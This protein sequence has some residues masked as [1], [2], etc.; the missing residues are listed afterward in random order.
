MNSKEIAPNILRWMSEAE[1]ARY[2]PRVTTGTSEPSLEPRKDSGEPEKLE[3]GKFA[4]WLKEQ[5]QAGRLEYFWQRTDKRATGKA[6]TPDFIVALPCG[7]T[8]WIE[9]KAPGG[10]LSPV[11][12]ATLKNLAILDH[13]TALCHSSAEAIALVARMLDIV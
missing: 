1:R 7:K 6:G 9:F 3:Q 8:Y 13:R 10:T 4:K 2:A 5:W 12:S 11:Q